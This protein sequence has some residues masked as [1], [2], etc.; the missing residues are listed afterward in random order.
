[1][2][3]RNHSVACTFAGAP[4]TVVAKGPGSKNKT[5]T[6]TIV[7]CNREQ[8]MGT[9]LPPL[10]WL[11]AKSAEHASTGQS[12]KEDLGDCHGELCLLSISHR[13]STLVISSK[14][15]NVATCHVLLVVFVSQ[16]KLV[17]VPS[18]SRVPPAPK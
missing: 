2:G 9:H 12:T 8:R 13:S 15:V 14:E 18:V 16:P 4:P 1:M 10:A 6:V 11:F 7:S 5:H 3:G 17:E